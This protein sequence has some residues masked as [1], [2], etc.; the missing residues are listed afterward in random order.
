MRYD[1]PRDLL[2]N[3][4][5]FN[6][7]VALIMGRHDMVTPT[8][9]AREYF[10]RIDA[11]LKAWYEFEE[12]AHFPHFEQPDR[13]TAALSELRNSWGECPQAAGGE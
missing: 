7:P 1:M 8:Q 6:I 11:P 12:S 3:E 13:F 5:Q 4:W 2:T 9:L 10:D